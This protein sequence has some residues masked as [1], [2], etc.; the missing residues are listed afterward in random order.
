ME[1]VYS[2]AK[3]AQ[4][5]NKSEAGEMSTIEEIQ[6][7]VDKKKKK[8]GKRNKPI[9]QDNRFNSDEFEESK[10]DGRQIRPPP[11]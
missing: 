11:K 3:F 4:S 8:E 10:I 6:E 2:P 9:A 1:S 7:S 5:G